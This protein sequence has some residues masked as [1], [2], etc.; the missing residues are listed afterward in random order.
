VIVMVTSV[1]GPGGVW[2]H[3]CDSALAL[4]GRGV[5]V[6]VALAPDAEALRAEAGALGLRLHD[7]GPTRGAVW[8]VHLAD[9]YDRALLVGA[10]S[11]R[12][13]GAVVV[14]T[15]HLP[16]TN[17]SDTS[18]TDDAVR[19]LPWWAKTLFK[20]VQ[21]RVAAATIAVSASSAAF[22]ALRYG[23][24]RGEI[25]VV[26]NGVDLTPG[27]GSGVAGDAPPVVAAAGAMLR[28]KG[29]DVL[30]RAL[31]AGTGGWRL[32]LAGRGPHLDAHRA[33]AA[34]LG[35]ADRVEFPGWADSAR[36]V[37][38]SARVV[39]VPSRWEAAAPYVVLE[40]MS[41]GR[42]VVATRFAGVDEAVVDGATGVLVGVD[43]HVALAA[44]LDALVADPA[45]CTAVGAAGRA[46]L[47]ELEELSVDGMTDGLLAVYD[48]VA[49]GAAVAAARVGRAS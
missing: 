47:G 37:F 7:A 3:V 4:R 22:L 26:H 13:A 43:D 45:R 29:F 24:R 30:L 35:V 40:A 11:A 9:T 15:E 27:A 38:R 19:R 20:T 14:V 44:A 32:V 33:L 49:P 25:D 8:H 16:R 12:R 21:F 1:T 6:R 5:D 18:L 10:V 39:A 2:R 23:R 17:A 36:S 48:R 41:E 31:A 28:Q 34:E 46:R 42:P